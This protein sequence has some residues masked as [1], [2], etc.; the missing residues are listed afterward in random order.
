VAGRGVH[1]LPI[2]C[3][4]LLAYLFFKRGEGAVERP[5]P[6]S[7]PWE[8]KT[9]RGTCGLI[10]GGKGPPSTARIKAEATKAGVRG[11]NK[12]GFPRPESAL[13]APLYRPNEADQ[14]IGAEVESRSWSILGA[15]DFRK[16]AH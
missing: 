10:Y 13:L 5:G 9:A 16:V 2:I 15:S 1:P 11:A 4:A 3:S 12:M 8:R 14:S 6:L 7:L